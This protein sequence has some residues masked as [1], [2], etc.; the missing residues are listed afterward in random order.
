MPKRSVEN[1]IGPSPNRV[2]SRSPLAANTCSMSRRQ[3]LN[4]TSLGRSRCIMSGRT[5]VVDANVAAYD[6]KLKAR[7][8]K[9]QLKTKDTLAPRRKLVDE[10]MNLK[11]IAPCVTASAPRPVNTCNNGALGFARLLLR[12]SAR[13][14]TAR[15]AGLN[16]AFKLRTRTAKTTARRIGLCSAVASLV[17]GAEEYHFKVA[18]R[19]CHAITGQAPLLP[20][21]AYAACS[22]CTF[23]SLQAWSLLI[24][25][26]CWLEPFLVRACTRALCEF[27][28]PYLWSLCSAAGTRIMLLQFRRILNSGHCHKRSDKSIEPDICERSWCG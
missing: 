11:M 13:S 10:I 26:S 25:I 22:W 2:V 21:I 28:C 1:K 15:L 19:A 9:A 20:C 8:I 23:L 24:H 27:L 18:L 12:I 3:G 16:I 4:L 6:G 7:T 5:N 17:A 14:T